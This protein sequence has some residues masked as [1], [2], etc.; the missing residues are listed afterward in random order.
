MSVII[1]IS[2]KHTRFPFHHSMPGM[3]DIINDEVKWR[4]TMQSAGEMYKQMG[5]NIMNM[6]PGDAMGGLGADPLSGINGMSAALDELS[7]GED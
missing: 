6:M 2:E 4:E 7:E 3:E 5:S 1:L